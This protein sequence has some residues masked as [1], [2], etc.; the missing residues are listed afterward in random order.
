MECS[1]GDTITLR[2]NS[3][4]AL[5]TT[6]APGIGAQLSVKRLN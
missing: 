4:V 6:L 3:A 2:N 1:A 5:M